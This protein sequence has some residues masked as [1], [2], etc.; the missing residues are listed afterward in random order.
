M[1]PRILIADD[2]FIITIHLDTLLKENG[3]GVAGIVHNAHDAVEHALENNPT[4]VIMDIKMP[5][6]LDGIDA[7]VIL[8]KEMDIPV[9]FL[10]GHD[11]PT[12]VERAKR[13]EPLAFLL[14]PINER[15]FLVE[16][17]I[18]LYKLNARRE[19]QL[20]SNDDFPA[21]LPPRY[22]ELTPSEL[23]VVSLIRKGKTTKEVAS[24]LDISE[25]T[26]MWH[27]KNIRKK[28]KLIGTNK[29]LTME[30]LK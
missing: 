13:V 21:E 8:I 2:D 11:D 23:R 4:L 18:A 7:A 5:G 29:S 1:E 10:S 30:L 25:Q 12:L 28:L 26:V 15:Q 14:K 9:I 22:A 6:K 20:F 27:R 24:Y 17:E 19:R 16:L 3:Y